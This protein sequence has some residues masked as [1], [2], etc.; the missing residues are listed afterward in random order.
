M[1]NSS[2]ETI[3]QK[4]NWRDRVTWYTYETGFTRFIK[5]LFRPFTNSLAKLECVGFENVPTNGPCIVAANHFSFFDVIYM[6]IY[7]PRYPHFMAKKE[8]YEYPLFGWAIRH[9]GSFPVYRGERDAWALSQAG[10]VLEAG[11]I[12]F[13]FPEGTRS[14]RKA[15]L[16]RGKPGAVKLALEHRAPIIPVAIWGTQDFKLGWKRMTVN[17]QIGEPLDVVSMA[18]PPPYKHETRQLTTLMMQ[19]IAEMLPPEHRGMYG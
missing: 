7:L 1:V 2:Q 9:L 12:L 17:I 4:S 18:G 16:R 15:Q 8:L 10:R 3:S 11:Q 19:K 6:G 14:G 13:M 5:A